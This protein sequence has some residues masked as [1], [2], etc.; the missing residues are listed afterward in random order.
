M[1]TKHHYLV[2]VVF[3]ILTLSGG[4]YRGLYTAQ[5]LA[6][7]E[8]ESGDVPLHRRFDLIAGTSIG[9][10]LALAIASGKTSMK[11][12]AAAMESQGSAIFGEDNPPK[13]KMAQY[14]DY[15]KTKSAARYDPAPL[16]NLIAELVGE[17]T[18]I[19]DLKQK[20]LVPAVNVTKGS[21]QAFKTPHHPRLVRDWKLPLVDVAMAT[22]AAPSYFPLHTIGSERFADGGMYANSP[23]DLA[24]HEAQYF[25]DQDLG[26]VEVLSIGTTT[27]KFSF[28]ASVASD[29]S[30]LDWIQEQRAISVMIAAQ[31]MNTDFVMRHRLGDR[32]IRVDAE[33]S[34]AQLSDITLDNANPKVAKDLM[35][36][37]ESSLRDYLPT[38][39]AAGIL[40]H[41]VDEEDFLQREEVSLYLK[42]L[43]G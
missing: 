19:G 27:S 37:A 9:G 23:D 42:R 22:S 41:T 40:D 1:V 34:A 17:D 2:V 6:G 26:D 36:L 33:P 18:Y 25:L 29:M 21:P 13:G 5:V 15:W 12:V 3:R 14:L 20:V 8:E 11:E 24:I 10:I 4:G 35:G 7:L 30:W 16:R 39:R 38:I 31:Q 28:P 32:Y 43:R